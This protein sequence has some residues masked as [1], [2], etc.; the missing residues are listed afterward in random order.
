MLLLA[1][2]A[3]SGACGDDPFAPEVIEEVEF[4]PSLGVDLSQMTKTA[5]GLY[6][7]DL[8]V[9]DGE[10]LAVGDSVRMDH[11]GWLTNGQL[12]STGVF[13]SKVG[14]A[15]LVPGFDE[16][17]LGMNVGGTRRLILPPELGYGNQGSGPIPPGAVM[18]FEVEILSKVE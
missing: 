14:V 16:G 1:A 6:F 18:I 17:V 3:G 4:A 9:G 2:I 12:F 10:A 8:V 13:E 5:S 11:S 15:H 7:Q